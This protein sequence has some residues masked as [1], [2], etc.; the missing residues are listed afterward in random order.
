MEE[1][2]KAYK[3]QDEDTLSYALFP[4]VATEFFKY[5]EAQQTGVDP[6]QADTRNKAYPVSSLLHKCRTGFLYP[7]LISQEIN[8]RSHPGFGLGGICILSDVIRMN[9]W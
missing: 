6:S 8:H 7:L 3:Q 9:V 1:A 2:V 5:R 4:Q